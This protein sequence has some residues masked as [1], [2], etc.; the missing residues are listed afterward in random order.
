MIA[1]TSWLSP[2]L[3]PR[4][5]RIEGLGLF[6]VAPIDAGEVVIRLGGRVIDGEALAALTPP[7]SSVALGKDRHLLMDPRPPGALRQPRL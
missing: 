6:A 2:R 4:P 7:Y 1:E 3:Q 5:S